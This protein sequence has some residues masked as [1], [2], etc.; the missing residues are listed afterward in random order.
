MKIKSILVGAGLLCLIPMNAKAECLK[1]PDV[2]VNTGHGA[3]IIFEEPVHE[4]K[5]FDPSQVVLSEIPEGGTKTLMLTQINRLTFP[6][7]PTGNGQTTLLAS[8]DE[9]T[10]YSFK[11]SFGNGNFHVS[12]NADGTDTDRSLLAAASSQFEPIDLALL[13]EGIDN[14]VARV[15]SDN[16][17]LQRAETFMSLVDSGIEQKT[18]AQ[19]LRLSWEHLSQLADSARFGDLG[20]TVAL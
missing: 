20:D 11:L 16:A 8:T 1:G 13:R 19:R 12:V 3:S 17:F 14:A 7:L 15:G 18:A 10:C 2:I 9:G 4:A 5:I 6:G